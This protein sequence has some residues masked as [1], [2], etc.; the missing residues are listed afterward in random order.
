MRKPKKQIVELETPLYDFVFLNENP[1][2]KRKKT[3]RRAESVMCT[4]FRN[5]NLILNAEKEIIVFEVLLLISG[6][7]S[8]GPRTAG[9]RKS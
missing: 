8:G 6:R 1:Y 5:E 2:A 7:P 3:N 9:S 4:I